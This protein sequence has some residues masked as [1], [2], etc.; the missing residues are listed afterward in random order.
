[1][2]S[3][4]LELYRQHCLQ[5]ITAALQKVVGRPPTLVTD[6][7]QFQKQ[8]IDPAWQA[9]PLPLR[10]Q[11][12]LKLR[13]DDFLLEGRKEVFRAA[14]GKLTLKPDAAARLEALAQRLFGE[15]ASARSM[16]SPAAAATAAGTTVG[17][18]IDLGTTCSAVA[19]LDAQRRPVS[20]P[21]TAGDL[22]TP[23]VVLF[24]EEGTAVGREAVQAAVTQPHRVADGAKRDLGSRAYRRRI[25]G[26]Y[27]PPEVITSLIL[28]HLRANAERRL[29][30]A[31]KA[32][33]AVPACF[34][35]ARRRA[36]MD[37]GRLAGL[38]VLDILNEPMAAALAHGYRLGLLAPDGK[39]AAAGPRRVLVFDL[40]GGIFDVTVV[41][42]EGR[43]F[44][45]LATGGDVA[46]GGK[47]W[48]DQLL[49][50]AAE[51]F[52]A[53]HRE[54][55][56]H[57]LASLQQLAQA[58]EAAKEALSEHAQAAIHVNH[59]GTPM[60]VEV[61][62]TA[63]EQATVVLLGRALTTTENVVRHSGLK[64]QNIDTILL[65][66]GAARM[67]MV[68]RMLGELAGKQA[69]QVVLPR[70][71]VARG[72]ALYAN[73][74]LKKQGQRTSAPAFTVTNINSHSLG[75]VGFDRQLDRYRNQIL[76]PKNTP[77][78]TTV[79]GTFKT[80]KDNQ[81]NVTVRIVEGE[82]E[83]PEACIEVGTFS[84]GNLPPNLPAGSPVQVSYTYHGN[85]RLKVT[86]GLKGQNRRVTMMCDRENDLD[87]EEMQ[88][89]VRC[90]ANQEVE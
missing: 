17:L 51:R 38:E 27:L 18:G 78:P 24:K 86:A 55:P 70:D 21:N 32:V 7:D 89:W 4:I 34:D 33:I 37:A 9:L 71:A 14:D 75:I 13:W 46:L 35:E 8:V 16:A 5:L 81:T 2:A 3:K 50:Y 77:L 52:K 23:S 62:R 73:L 66:G 28:R 64:W 69:E 53:R 29:G 56:R 65:A 20:I 68:Q 30:A 80:Y 87:K 11:G 42:I 6:A 63:F 59:R 49:A 48:D 22:L 41:E 88:L 43:A 76:I 61:T 54:D 47:D 90:L 25:N 40:G 72:A 36:T 45:A 10:L 67:P 83:R 60:V 12:R 19:H 44:R 74:L 31:R 15:T 85:G 39:A 82:S 26:D 79:S 58:A 57:D 84:I 1:M